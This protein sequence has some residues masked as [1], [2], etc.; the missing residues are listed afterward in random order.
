MSEFLSI[1][2]KK[3]TDVDLVKPLKNII[4]SHYNTSDNPESYN[5]AIEEFNKLRNQA[6]WKVYE[7]YE[8]SLEIV[9]YYYDELAS[10][11]AK[12]AGSSPQIPFKWKDAFDKGSLFSGRA[13]LTLTSFKYEIICVLFNI[14]ALQSAIASTQ[15]VETDGGLKLAAKLFQLAAGIY[16][17][18][19]ETV[20]ESF[21]QDLT[22]DMS[23]ETLSALTYLMLAQAQEIFVLKAIHDQMK[24]AIVAKLSAQCAEYYSDTIKVLQ[25]DQVRPLVG[26]SWISLVLGKQLIFQGLAEYFQSSVCKVNKEI[27][28][29]I[30]R[31]QHAISNIKNGQQQSAKNLYQDYLTKATR[32]L[33]DAEK[34]NN[35]I[36]H[37]AVPDVK[38][39]SAIAKAPVAKPTP[40]PSRLSSNFQDLFRDLMPVAIHQALA[41]YDVRKTDLMNMEVNKLRESTQLLNS[42]LA[43]LN[44]PAALEDTNGVTV[45]PSLLEK[46]EAVR[47][48]GG[49]DKIDSMI[50]ELPDLLKCNQEILDA[51]AEMLQEEKQSDD[52][53]RAQFREKWKR[54]ESEK[55]TGSIRSNLDMYKQMIATAV[56]ADSVVREKYLKHKQA[57]MLLST[58][59]D[60]IEKALPSGSSCGNMQNTSAISNLKRLLEEVETIKAER[61]A[62]ESELKSVTVDMK[63]TFL[64]ALA[65]DGAINE[66][67]LSNESLGRSYGELQKQVKES[68]EKQES[69]LHNIQVQNTEFSKEKDNCVASIHRENFLKELAAGFDAYNELVKNLQEGIKFY[70][71]LTQH[72]VTFQNKVTDFCFAR[73]TEKEELLRSL[74]QDA[75]KM[76]PASNVPTPPTASA[77]EKKEAPPRPP[78]PNVP[79]VVVDGSKTLPYPSAFPRGMPLPYNV[80]G[81][82]AYPPPPMPTSYNPYATLPQ[83]HAYPPPQQQYANQPYPPQQ[84]QPYPYYY[85]QP[86]PQ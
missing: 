11:E 43:S 7:K 47:R 74:T 15:I 62:I 23:T 4:A 24:D 63:A 65:H 38:N 54:S 16:K 32:A 69:L 58:G 82:F 34:D 70:K 86:P 31:L 21:H 66:A 72:L 71:N 45:P 39:L 5:T 12:L 46:S 27:G 77:P 9:Y 30:A 8:S 79:P 20:S 37:E 25:K 3:P 64:S 56:N 57:I 29:E 52:E 67:E 17:H 75:S 35:F 51:T 41:A 81:A 18:I 73:K 59:P 42:V 85:Q 44:L 22:P 83:M 50:R 40:L 2:V 6:V 53:L 84:Y 26:N 61:D 28:E 48:E 1:P 36:Y 19:K 13:S 80:T 68:I 55:L 10:L 33:A 78:A 60:A 49:V 76:P 14:G